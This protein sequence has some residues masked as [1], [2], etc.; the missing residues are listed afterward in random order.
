MSI[1]LQSSPLIAN[2]YRLLEKIGQ[3]GMGA[4]YR[5]QDRLRATTVALKRVELPYDPSKL[6]LPNQRHQTA[7]D[8]KAA[9]RLALVNEFRLLAALRH[10]NIVSVLD[11]GLETDGTPFFT[12]ELIEDS[13]PFVKAISGYSLVDK[14]KTL[15]QL[16]QA[17]VYLHRHDIVHHD[18]KPNN[19][20]IDST[21]QVRVVDFGLAIHA[22]D[23]TKQAGTLYYTAPEMIDGGIA[24]VATD[25][26]SFGVMCYEALLGERPFVMKSISQ[27][28]RDVLKKAVDFHNL[29]DS[30]GQPL[31]DLITQL[32]SKDPQ[33]RPADASSVIREM[34]AAVGLATPLETL[35]IR[36][37]FLQTAQFVG[38]TSEL[39][40]LEQALDQANR[41]TGSIWFIAGES[42]VGKTRLM[43]ELRIRALVKNVRVLH[44]KFPE[45]SHTNFEL[46]RTPIE[47]LLLT[48]PIAPLEASILK[49]LV[50]N[51]D[52]L[53]ECPVENSPPL[54]PLARQDR[55]MTAIVEL[56]ARQTEP[57]LLLLDDL[58][59][60][61]ADLELLHLLTKAVS[62]LPLLIVSS[63]RQEEAPQLADQFSN[64]RIIKL[65]RLAPDEIEQLS[66]AILGESGVRKSLQTLLYRETEGNTFFLIEVLRMLAEDAGQLAKIGIRPL[67]EHV[68]PVGVA[69]IIRRRLDRLSSLD[70]QVLK[71]AAVYGRV[72]NFRVIAH[73]YPDHQLIYW[74]T[75]CADAGILTIAEGRPEFAHDKLRAVI[76]SSIEP[77]LLK[78]FHLQ[79]AETLEELYLHEASYTPMLADHLQCAGELAR[80]IPYQ[81]LEAERLINLGELNR[82]RTL[83]MNLLIEVERQELPQP[84]ARMMRWYYL[85]G[86]TLEYGIMM[87]GSSE[88]AIGWFERSLVLS[89]KLNDQPL[90][91]ETLTHMALISLEHYGGNEASEVML[92]SAEAICQQLNDYLGLAA[93]AFVRANGRYF[94][95]KY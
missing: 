44:G 4:V 11:Y 92:T 74:V 84:D 52:E 81:L 63:Y 24:T 38:R 1:A 37:S 85:L 48:T 47:A 80:A 41:G 93:I 6:A 56:F 73:C 26:Y 94:A 40:Q 43:D 58:Q 60:A 72:I 54:S 21:G 35:A 42:G 66:T 31:T 83:L 25:L 3:G 76:I 10:P 28:R 75:H 71:F 67:P 13:Q 2:R 19:V 55:L 14:I 15:L 27:L 69:N 20:L 51:I 78:H 88:E 16:L 61:H 79:I 36:N 57:I 62:V 32:L 70:Q 82:A 45:N 22:H 87:V 30:L 33:Q 89:M 50:P 65:P 68:F 49:A 53:I 59:F 17:L 77:D 8:S 46:W 86:K 5:A 7:S 9:S 90:I 34:C 39:T 64:A 29:R 18:L 91:A 95:G 12:M 23:H